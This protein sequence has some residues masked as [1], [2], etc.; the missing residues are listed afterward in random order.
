MWDRKSFAHKRTSLM[1]HFI[2]QWK[3]FLQLFNVIFSFPPSNALFSLGLWVCCF[4]RLLFIVWDL[5]ELSRIEVAIEMKNKGKSTEFRRVE[6][7]HV[8]SFVF[9]WS[10]SEWRKS[11]IFRDVRSYDGNAINVIEIV[12]V[13]NVQMKETTASR[14]NRSTLNINHNSNYITKK[15]V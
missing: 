9:P 8:I 3:R 13:K 7:F 12:V 1:L 6:N 14:N 5:I 2:L 15:Q 4:L 10:L 11:T